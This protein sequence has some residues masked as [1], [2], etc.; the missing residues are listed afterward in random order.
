MVALEPIP[1][2]L[3]E[4]NM[5]Q[6]ITGRLK[7]AEAILD[8]ALEAAVGHIPGDIRKELLPE[9]D[10][11]F[12]ITLLLATGHNTRYRCLLDGQHLGN[13]WAADAYEPNPFGTEDSVLQL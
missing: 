6:V 7:E 8:K 5:Q 1:A 9:E 4:P 10:G 12:S 3:G 13:K 2:Y 11:G